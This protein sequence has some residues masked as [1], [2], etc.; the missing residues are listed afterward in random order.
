MGLPISEYTYAM[1]HIVI[2]IIT[3]AL[4]SFVYHFVWQLRPIASNHISSDPRAGKLAAAIQLNMESINL[5]RSEM[6]E[7]QKMVSRDFELAKRE[8]YATEKMKADEL[9]DRLEDVENFIEELSV[10][11]S[12]PVEKQYD[13]TKGLLNGSSS[14]SIDLA[15]YY[16]NEFENDSGVPLDDFSDSI[17]ETLHSFEGIKV[18]GVECGNSVC[19]IN[20]SKME[21][22]GLNEVPDSEYE[23]EEKL[24]LSAEGREVEVR[25]A[26]DSY[27]S[28]VMYIQLR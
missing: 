21:S 13:K 3:A 7:L 20:Y 14:S 25:Y 11:G 16:Q 10:A 17:E 28:D 27:G 5:L 8:N 12:A 26:T 18:N 19:K 22:V 2:P 15:A 4:V 23:L 6:A 9:I 24:S 1:K